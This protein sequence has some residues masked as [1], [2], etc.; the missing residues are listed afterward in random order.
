LWV[1]LEPCISGPFNN[2]HDF[3]LGHLK[4]LQQKASSRILLG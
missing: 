2:F 3:Y 4:V 1:I